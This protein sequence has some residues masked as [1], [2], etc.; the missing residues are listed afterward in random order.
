M[1]LGAK[2]AEEGTGD[3]LL[4]TLP[5]YLYAFTSECHDNYYSIY[6]NDFKHIIKVRTQVDSSYY[7]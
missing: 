7:I 4:Q 6:S 1:D 5:Y 2:E 3:S